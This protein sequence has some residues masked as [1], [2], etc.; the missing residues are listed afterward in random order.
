MAPFLWMYRFSSLSWRHAAGDSAK[1]PTVI[2]ISSAVHAMMHGA[3]LHWMLYAT[4]LVH[5]CMYVCMYVCIHCVTLTLT[6]TLRLFLFN[7]T[8]VFVRQHAWLPRNDWVL[9]M[10]HSSFAC[11][12][13]CTYVCMYACTCVCI[14]ICNT[15]HLRA[16]A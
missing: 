5:V 14:Y 6:L 4:V 15:R 2:K 8:C 16:T 13:A 10:R 1:E 3:P 7:S 11:I 9:I 12:C